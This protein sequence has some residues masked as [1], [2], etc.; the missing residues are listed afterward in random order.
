LNFGSNPPV[1]T[2]IHTITLKNSNL[3]FPRTTQ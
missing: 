1:S 3:S 2:T